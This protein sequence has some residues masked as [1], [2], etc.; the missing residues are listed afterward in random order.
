LS[1]NYESIY[2]WV[3]PL[4]GVGP[5]TIFRKHCFG[6]EEDDDEVMETRKLDGRLLRSLPSWRTERTW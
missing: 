1:E 6:I 2:Q 5:L 4:E 3:D